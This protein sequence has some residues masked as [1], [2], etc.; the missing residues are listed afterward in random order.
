MTNKKDKSIMRKQAHN[1]IEIYFMNGSFVRYANINRVDCFDRMPFEEKNIAGDP[2]FRQATEF[3]AVEESEEPSLPVGTWFR[4]FDDTG[5]RHPN[6]NKRIKGN[7][8]L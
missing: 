7:R 1:Y 2:V 5:F 3:R 6:I 4:Y 8:W